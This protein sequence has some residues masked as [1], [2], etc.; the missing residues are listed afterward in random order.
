MYERITY[1]STSLSNP[2]S[3]PIG[4]SSSFPKHYVI[5]ESTFTSV[6]T[7]SVRLSFSMTSILLKNKYLSGS[8]FHISLYRN[9]VALLLFLEH[10]FNVSITIHVYNVN[11]SGYL[12]LVLSVNSGKVIHYFDS[13]AKKIATLLR[14]L[15]TI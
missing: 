8:V 12:C 3:Y 10:L 1:H 11:R 15:L 9:Y 13:F 2:L 4:F 7:V 6:R 5:L 14:I